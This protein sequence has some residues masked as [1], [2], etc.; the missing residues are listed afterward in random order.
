MADARIS[1][2][3]RMDNTQFIA[4]AQNSTAAMKQVKTE[5]AELAKEISGATSIAN[6]FASV[7]RGDLSTGIASIGNGLNGLAPKIMALLGPLALVAGAFAAAYKAGKELD[8]LTGISDAV[9]RRFGG[10]TSATDALAAQTEANRK[11]RRERQA[12]AEEAQKIEDETR[13]KAEARLRGIAK[14]ESDYAKESAAIRKQI[15]EAKTSVVK[16]ALQA[17]LDAI[18]S[19]HKQDVAAAK[20][21]EQEKLESVRR[22]EAAKIEAAKIASENRTEQIRN[23]NERMFISSLEG[24]NRI[25]AEFE[26]SVNDVQKEIDD[27]ETTPEQRALLEQRKE[28]IVAERQRR[29]DE[30]DQIEQA[31][32]A[33]GGAATMR[34][35]DSF[36]AV[37]GQLGSDRGDIAAM[38]NQ[39][40]ER[41]SQIADGSYGVTAVAEKD[42]RERQINTQVLKNNVQAISVLTSEIRSLAE[43]MSGGVDI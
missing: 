6:G 11:A 3:M 17:Q 1:A 35:V 4:A 31:K 14:M 29:L 37:G 43:A 39:M 24:V 9:A 34:P 38:Q 12:A 7:L 18:T 15:E 10:D 25:Q 36:R 22:A 23:E 33:G 42:I 16:N 26:R 21:A 30:L 2:E 19:Y 40:R 5:S 8:R 20:A 41:Q 32:D 13:K 27:A 28:L